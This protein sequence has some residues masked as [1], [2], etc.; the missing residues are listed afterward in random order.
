[1]HFF[2]VFCFPLNN[3]LMGKTNCPSRNSSGRL[4]SANPFSLLLRYW[5]RL[6]SKFFLTVVWHTSRNNYFWIFI[7]RK[8]SFRGNDHPSKESILVSEARSKKKTD[9]KVIA[10]LK[11]A[12]DRS[13][14]RLQ[15]SKEEIQKFLW[16]T[17]LVVFSP[18]LTIII[19][20]HWNN[21]NRI[22]SHEFLDEQ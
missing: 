14:V 9:G 19:E 21:N 12:Y 1:M 17:I 5:K 11:V 16:E 6:Y 2:G 18:I 15:Y 20:F 13:E 4:L 7:L 22:S 8:R 10:K 3:G